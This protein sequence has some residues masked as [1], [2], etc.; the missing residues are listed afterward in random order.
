M[1]RIWG[2]HRAD[3]DKK[4]IGSGTILIPIL[5]PIPI[6]AI[7]TPCPFLSFSA[8][9]PISTGTGF[10]GFNGYGSFLPTLFKYN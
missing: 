8:L 7:P 3:I 9:I 10:A 1:E 6:L 2:E 5:V 4:G